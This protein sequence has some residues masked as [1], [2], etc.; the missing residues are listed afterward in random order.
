MA[1]TSPGIPEPGPPRVDR[2]ARQH[3]ADDDYWQRERG[4]FSDLVVAVISN[5]KWPAT[6]AVV[7]LLT[8]AALAALGIMLVVMAV[9][10]ILVMDTI[11]WSQKDV[12]DPSQRVAAER[13]FGGIKNTVIGTLMSAT[14]AMAAILFRRR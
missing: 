6:I 11:S 1:E 3:E 2:L 12:L 4:A 7:M 10:V 8:A 13:M 9:P 14:L 5:L